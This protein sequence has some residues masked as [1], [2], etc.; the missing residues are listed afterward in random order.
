MTATT[1]SAPSGKTVGRTE[2]R[3]SLG[4]FSGATVS[5]S[6]GPKRKAARGRAVR[7]APRRRSGF[8][9]IFLSLIDRSST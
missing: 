9:D 8:D 3:R 6:T 2:L 1:T 5:S 7:A 4:T